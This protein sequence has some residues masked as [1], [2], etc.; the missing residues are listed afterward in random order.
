MSWRLDFSCGHL[1]SIYT[2]SYLH[3]LCDHHTQAFSIS[4]LYTGR[5]AYMCVFVHMSGGGGG[6]VV[7]A[8][9]LRLPSQFYL[10]TQH[11][12]LS[13]V[14]PLCLSVCTVC[15]LAL[16]VNRRQSLKENV[17]ADNS[18]SA[19]ICRCLSGGR[20]PA[21]SLN[22]FAQLSPHPAEPH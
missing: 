18:A 3:T 9:P 4:M 12:S 11:S 7:I 22:D 6:G 15:H 5:C 14:L 8:T 19:R 2:N 13:V 1:L 20:Q 17:S 16:P 10:S 21:T